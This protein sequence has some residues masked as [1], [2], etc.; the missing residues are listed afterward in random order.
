MNEAAFRKCVKAKG[1]AIPFSK[2]DGSIEE[3]LWMDDVKLV[4]YNGE[5]TCKDQ[6]Y[7]D[8]SPNGRTITSKRYLS[9]M[10]DAVMSAS[11]KEIAEPYF[12][13][14]RIKGVC[15]F[16]DMLHVYLTDED[17]VTILRDLSTKSPKE[18][19]LEWNLSEWYC[20]SLYY[21]NRNKN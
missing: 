13:K 14:K 12:F 7:A 4:C 16:G 8:L 15:R 20:K 18:V 2:T 9:Q 17:K 1:R 10:L 19:A 21:N 5:V 6:D 3:C 11:E